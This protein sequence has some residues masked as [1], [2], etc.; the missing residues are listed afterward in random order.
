M[1]VPSIGFSQFYVENALKEMGNS[2]TTLPP[3]SFLTWVQNNWHRR[4]PGMGEGDR[5]DRK[6]VV[7]LTL[8]KWDALTGP[9]FFCPPRVKLVPGMPLRVEVV[10]RPGSTDEDY[11]PEVF[12]TP[13]DAKNYEYIE[14][15]AKQVGVVCYSAAALLENGG[16]RTGTCDWEI[17]TLLCSP[18]EDGEERMA[19]TT[20]ARNWLEMPGGTKPAV[21]Y[22]C[23]EWAQA[24][25]DGKRQGVKVRKP[26][27]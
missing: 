20:M 27:N 5:I 9:V 6:V 17:I 18:D 24:V 14:V 15:P 8:V 2:Y 25:W 13:E 7:P 11:Y 1:T 12:I 22:T 16:T 3:L 4:K 10:K 26:R 23:D 21:P 19:P